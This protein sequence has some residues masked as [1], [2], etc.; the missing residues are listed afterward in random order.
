M[1]TESYC[2][3]NDLTFKEANELF[4]Y[5]GGQLFWKARGKSRRYKK[6]VGWKAPNGYL[7]VEIGRKTYAVH[8]I[9][10]V[11]HGNQ[12]TESIDHINGNVTDNR[13]ENLRGATQSQ[14]SMNRRLRRDS[15]SGIKGVSWNKQRNKWRAGVTLNGKCYCAG[16]FECKD[17]AAK[18]VTSLRLQL[19]GEFAKQV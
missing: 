19:H 3:K 11:L 15:R 17:D 14:N 9:I 4:T 2:R 5:S 18:A 1:T 7:R 10:W 12:L 16:Y 8:R 13:I 6:P